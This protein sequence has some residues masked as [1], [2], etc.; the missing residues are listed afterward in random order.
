MAALN[1]S[2][3]TGRGRRRGQLLLV[4]AVVL[5]SFLVSLTLVLN[6]GV[7]AQNLSTRAGESV[8]DGATVTGGTEAA[9]GGLLEVAIDAAPDA[10][11]TQTDTVVAGVAALGAQFGRNAAQERSYT[12]ITY[13]GATEGTRLVQPA[14]RNFTNAT[15]TGDWGL[16]SGVTGLR[17]FRLN[18]TR[19]TLVDVSTAANGT[20]DA[21]RV[22]LSDGEGHRWLV[23]VY[24]VGGET[25][26]HATDVDS[27]ATSV[28]C[29]DT[30][31][32]HSVVDVTAGTLDGERC[33]A[34]E[35]FDRRPGRLETNAGVTVEYVG[36]VV[37]GAP[38]VAGSYELT[39]DVEESVVDDG[40]F[41]ADGSAAAPRAEAALYAVDVRLAHETRSLEYA[42]RLRVAPGEPD[43]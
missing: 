20:G 33:P 32:S 26:V 17:Q 35:L 23:Y 6:A 11:A 40:D 37:G 12:N 13:L 4:G 21:F 24:R 9:V 2:G 5:A 28:V 19:A 27:G 10:T 34:L 1:R 38:T 16:V 30:T 36:A 31:G 41:A 3:A 15:G 43:G 14:E 7:Y 29:R 42:T 8:V 25:R 22:R 39:V 18:V